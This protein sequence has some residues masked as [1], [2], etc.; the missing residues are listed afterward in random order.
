[1]NKEK[2]Q[3]TIY[4]L[5]TDE[6]IVEFVKNR[7]QELEE[8]SVEVF[9]GQNY[10][11]TFK[12]YISSKIHYKAGVR[13]GN[14]ECPDLVFDDITPYVELIKKIKQ[15]NW[16]S[17]LTLF[18]TIFYVIY[19]YLPSDDLL[20]RAF[21][22]VANKGK[23]ISIKTI[24]ENECAFCSEK[25]GLAHNMFKFLG[26]DSELACGYRNSEAHAFNLIY[27]HGYGNEPMVIY[28]PSFFV[29]FIKG[30]Q[31]FSLGYFKA[32]KKED[33]EKLMQGSPIKAELAKTEKQYRRVYNFD[34]SYEFKGDEP[35]YLIG[36]SKKNTKPTPDKK[37]LDD[38]YYTTHLENGM[39]EN[40]FHL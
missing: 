23:R 9:A 21:T 36:L 27:P 14:D 25:A 18:S 38:L 10:T 2:I 13:I 11:D 15:D 24:K 29:D 32:L 39:E 5:K 17:E 40:T 35:I 19:A 1:M 6:E 3:E 20:G 31:K 16:Y 34:E 12:E 33:Y 26:I 7:L 37:M 30:S 28:D 4:G 8:N 22:Y